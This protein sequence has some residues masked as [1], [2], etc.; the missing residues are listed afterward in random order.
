MLIS[1]LNLVDT[2]MVGRLGDNAI[3]SVGVA[4][5]LSFFINIVLFGVAS[6]GAVFI[7]QYH[8]A[9]D[10]KNIR[11]VFG[12]VLCINVPLALL[13][14]GVCFFRAGSH[15]GGL[16]GRA[17]DDRRGGAVPQNRVLCVYRRLAQSDDERCAPLHGEGAGCP[18]SP[19]WRRR[20]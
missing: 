20:C 16:Y 12:L 9:N 18:C 15:G 14:C 4:G 7:A 11:R 13:M 8:G 2:L 17:R 5:Q 3:A 6:G 1:S 10:P 19:A